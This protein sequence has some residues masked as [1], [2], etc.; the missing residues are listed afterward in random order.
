MIQNIH[1][2]IKIDS[3]EGKETF[4]DIILSHITVIDNIEVDIR[5]EKENNLGNTENYKNIQD[6]KVTEVFFCGG[7][8]VDFSRIVIQIIPVCISNV[9]GNLM[10]IDD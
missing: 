8:S 6:T 7:I 1:F 3:L 4:Q 2:N 10:D 9:K 5:V